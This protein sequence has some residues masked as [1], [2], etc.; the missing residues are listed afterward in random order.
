MQQR[1]AAATQR[2]APQ[3]APPHAPPREEQK[4]DEHEVGISYTWSPP[5]QASGARSAAGAR[6]AAKK[7]EKKLY[8]EAMAAL[9]KKEAAAAGVGA[10]AQPRATKRKKSR[11]KTRG[12]KQ[13]YLGSK[14]SQIWAQKS[15]GTGGVEFEIVDG[16]ES[17]SAARAAIVAQGKS[18]FRNA[19]QG[20]FSLPPASVSGSGTGARRE[21]T[22][23]L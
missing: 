16:K 18:M 23:A 2:G 15:G 14:K 22:Y 12:G 11:A 1:R 9:K 10:A 5:S 13:R 20:K 21:K 6:R 17:A 19:R 3:L 8:A 7:K 4:V